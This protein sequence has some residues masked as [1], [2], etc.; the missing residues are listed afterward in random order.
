M[1]FKQELSRIATDVEE[2]L[3]EMLPRQNADWAG[4]PANAARY[5]ALDAG[6]RLRTFLTVQSAG[7]FDAPY[8]SS[9]RAGAV[10]EMIHNYSLIH[11]DLPCM[12]NDQLR[13]GRPSA[14]AKYGE[15]NALLA[16]NFLANW[17]YYILAID[18]K[19]SA[20]AA[21]R[22]EL[23]KILANATNGMLL[24]QYMDCDAADFGKFQS[25]EAIDK[26]QSLKTGQIFLACTMFG[27][28]LGGADANTRAALK[29]FT[30]AMGLCFQITDDILDATGDQ[31]KVGKTLHKDAAAGKATYISLLGLDGARAK[32][33][34]LAATAK[35]ALSIFDSR[36]D[37]LR[38]M[39]DYMVTRES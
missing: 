7:L 26:I 19:I 38:E 17:P 22:L 37:H 3:E 2:V 21:V 36:A 8:E 32:A 25:A 31:E 27:A 39:M 14:W 34:E 15:R 35:D 10:I 18:D 11:D 12:D 20:D 28:T 16:G 24:G 13:R 9:L 33:T 29:K 30:D 23:T 4:A 5:A 6:K 1:P